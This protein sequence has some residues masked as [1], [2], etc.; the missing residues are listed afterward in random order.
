MDDQDEQ[1]R[2]PIQI[3]LY[4]VR[5]GITPASGE[6][7]SPRSWR[8]VWTIVHAQIRGIVTEAFGL[9]GDTLRG[10]RN[11]VRGI[12]AIPTSVAKRIEIAH[13]QADQAELQR[14]GQEPTPDMDATVRDLVAFLRSKQVQ[15]FTV[16]AVVRDE[17]LAICFLPPTDD[18]DASTV[19]HEANAQLLDAQS[20]AQLVDERL[21]ELLAKP[22]EELDLSARTANCLKNAEIW[23]IGDLV[24]RT[25]R[26]MLST[27]NFGR[28]SLNEL[29][30]VLASLGLSLGMPIG[31]PKLRGHS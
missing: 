16:R 30:D 14:R 26:Q 21:R 24:Q 15:G 3:D 17:G 31:P 12:G 29:K 22:W 18:D 19:L 9:V 28:K 8:E 11:L 13:Q 7:A 23:T 5:I 25:E 4:G 2:E 20:D 1:E 27:K 6:P 10:A